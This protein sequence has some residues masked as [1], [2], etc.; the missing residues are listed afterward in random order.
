MP[1]TPAEAFAAL[2]P[3][4]QAAVLAGAHPN[5]PAAPT[6]PPEP[7]PYIDPWA[8]LDDFY[9]ETLQLRYRDR[10]YVLH[11]VDAETGLLCQRLVN[12][13]IG[14]VTD[15]NLAGRALKAQEGAKDTLDDSTEEALYQRLLGGD[16]DH[17]TY[18]PA[19]DLW[20]QLVHV[21]RVPW[22]LVRH[23]GV[24]AIMWAGRDRT[25]ALDYWLSGARP[26]AP[27][28][29][30]PSTPTPKQPADRRPSAKAGGANT[31]RSRA[32]TSSTTP[33]ARKAP[34]TRGSSS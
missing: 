3:D 9:D 12:L 10:Q 15:Y 4:E 20:N 24:T 30:S 25:T 19:H 28:D 8:Q 22:P 7:E 14:A 27:A 29:P 33:R 23:M 11:A 34:G 32:S 31:T 16:K 17:P 13:G 5:Q 2:T 21:E 26:K 6:T 1:L 18:D